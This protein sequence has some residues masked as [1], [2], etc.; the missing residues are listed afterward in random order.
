VGVMRFPKNNVTLDAEGK[1]YAEFLWILIDIS[2]HLLIFNFFFI[3]P[4]STY[5]T[6]NSKYFNY[7]SLSIYMN[8][9]KG[10]RW[11]G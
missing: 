5:T 6:T 8:M 4:K 2:K 10:G 11:Y 9:N 7:I 1:I 3:L